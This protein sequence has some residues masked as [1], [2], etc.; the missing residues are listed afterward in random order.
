MFFEIV[1]ELS[2]VETIASGRGIKEI[3]R[4]RYRDHQVSGR[5]SA[6]RRTALV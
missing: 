3:A 6:Y 1:G 2:E 5:D 4:L